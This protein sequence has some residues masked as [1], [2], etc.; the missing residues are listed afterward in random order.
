MVGEFNVGKK[1]LVQK[2]PTED[3]QRIVL[4]IESKQRGK[5]EGLRA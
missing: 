3:I 4:L 5:R 1:V 2:M